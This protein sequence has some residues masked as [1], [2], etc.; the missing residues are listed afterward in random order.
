MFRWGNHKKEVFLLLLIHISDKTSFARSI[1]IF[2]V[3]KNFRVCN[4]SDFTTVCLFNW[5]LRTFA[6][7]HYQSYVVHK[8]VLKMVQWGDKWNGSKL[9]TKLDLLQMLP[10]LISI[11]NVSMWR[12]PLLLSAHCV[13]YENIFLHN[14]LRNPFF[15]F[16]ATIHSLFIDCVVD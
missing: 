10:P 16:F 7:L 12:K 15:S 11:Y 9:V 14:H 2:Q 6:V 4:K 1:N 13:W 5:F 8:H 3:A